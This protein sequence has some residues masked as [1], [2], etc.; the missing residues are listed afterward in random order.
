MRDWGGETF[1]VCLPFA[2]TMVLRARARESRHRGPRAAGGTCASGRR[3][4]VALP[5]RPAVLAPSRNGNAGC[6]G[7]G[8]SGAG[9]A[10]GAGGTLPP[11]FL[12]CLFP[13]SIA[14]RVAGLASAQLWAT[15]L[16]AR[17][18]LSWRPWMRSTRCQRGGSGRLRHC[19][20]RWR[21]PPSARSPRSLLA[22]ARPS[23]PPPLGW[24]GRCGPAS[25]ACSSARRRGLNWHGSRGARPL[26]CTRGVGQGGGVRRGRRL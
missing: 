9:G 6:D 14:A 25:W 8:R 3:R 4:V 16:P 2:V 18:S 19:R 13:L 26:G 21:R 1:A 23:R 24:T 20:R 7:G 12:L 5:R 17:R 15:L 22:A 10:G 11:S